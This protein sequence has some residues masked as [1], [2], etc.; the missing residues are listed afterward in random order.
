MHAAKLL[1]ALTL[2]VLPSQLFAQDTLLHAPPDILREITSY[3]ETDAGVIA[4]ARSLLL[5]C[6]REGD[7]ARGRPVLAYLRDHYRGSRYVPLWAAERFLLSY[8]ESDYRPILNPSRLDA[9]DTLEYENSVTPPRDLLMDDLR[10]ALRPLRN[11][12]RAAIG[13]APLT[14]EESG[15]LVLFLESLLGDRRDP[16]VQAALNEDADA[17]LSENRGS[18]YAP[19]VRRDIRYVLRESRWGHGFT[20]GAGAGAINGNLGKLFNGM[21]AFDVG[22]DMGVRQ[23]V[24]D[25]DGVVYFRI[26]VG[27]GGKVR[28]PFTYDGDWEKGA[29][30]DVAI[31]ELSVGLAVFE[32]DLVQIAPFGGISGILFSPPSGASG[33]FTDNLELDLFS[34]SAGLNVDWKI[35]PGQGINRG[36]YFLIRTRLTLAAP[37]AVPER[38]FSGNIVTF[39][40]G[41]G[42]FGRGVLRDL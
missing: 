34:L 29:K 41:F 19:F 16:D 13:R 4:K 15:F 32:S 8:W 37:V 9:L 5:D 1:T 7:T 30:Q 17:F 21:G 40:V 33:N 23:L 25:L 6:V 20:A 26:S 35:S 36:S 24:A 18:R 3:R 39:T 28:M 38:R 2:T 31:P 12:L 42:L 22:Y 14:R 11:D 10:D 27:L